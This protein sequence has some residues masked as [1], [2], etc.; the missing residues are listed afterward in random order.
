MQTLATL[1]FE[2]FFASLIFI[3]VIWD[4]PEGARRFHLPSAIKGTIETFLDTGGFPSLSVFIAAVVAI[5]Q[6]SDGLYYQTTLLSSVFNF[7]V[8]P[9]LVVV[10][11]HFA[12]L[13]RRKL[14]IGIVVALTLPSL[15]LFWLAIPRDNNRF[16]VSWPRI[17]C[18]EGSIED[19]YV[20]FMVNFTLTLFLAHQFVTPTVFYSLNLVFRPQ[21]WKMISAGDTFLN[22]VRSLHV[23]RQKLR[24]DR[25]K[26]RSACLICLFELYRF[27]IPD[28]Q[29]FGWRLAIYSFIFTWSQ[30][31]F[32]F[33]RRFKLGS[34]AKG[35]VYKENQLGFGQ[36]LAALIWLPVLA[37][38]GDILCS[39]P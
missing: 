35:G 22:S 3:D 31:G 30:L 8:G 20:V 11:L 32:I 16:M 6:F 38:F 29:P 21:L 24:Q 33:Y 27:I 19:D 14:R 23:E 18:P 25:R 15:V 36:T 2:A 12:Q 39:K 9:L 34:C 1:A 26:K 7:T 4:I 13:R 5:G 28:D 17:Y 10:S 37:D